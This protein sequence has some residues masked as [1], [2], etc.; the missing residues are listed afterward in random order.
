MQVLVEAMTAEELTRELVPLFEETDDETLRNSMGMVLQ[1]VAFDRKRGKTDFKGFDAYLKGA[2][3]PPAGLIEFMFRTDR[4]QAAVALTRV[5]EG[6]AAAARLEQALRKPN[7]TGLTALAKSGKWW[8]QL[9]VAHTVRRVHPL[10]SAAV[11]AELRK[12]PHPLV[13]K[14]LAAMESDGKRRSAR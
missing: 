2:K 13:K 10:R 5:H 11:M 14:V 6:D 4:T 9:F 3:T 12:A 1:L 7:A 8:K